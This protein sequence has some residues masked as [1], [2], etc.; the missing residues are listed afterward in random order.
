MAGEVS[1]QIPERVVTQNDK[2]EEV[3]REGVKEVVRLPVGEVFGESTLRDNAKR[4]VNTFAI[5]NCEFFEIKK[6]DYD[7]IVKYTI[8]SVMR[9]KYVF[10][11]EIELFTKISRT[12]FESLLYLIDQ[13]EVNIGHKLYIEGDPVDYIYVVKSGEFRL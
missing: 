13:K 10:M 12:N 6:R 9:A 1:V 2:G 7:I 8:M 5:T 11:E 4:A 3:V